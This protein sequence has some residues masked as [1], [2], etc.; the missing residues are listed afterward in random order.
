[1]NR[2]QFLKT[3]SLALTLLSSHAY[4]LKLE[5]PQ[6]GAYLGAYADFGLGAMTMN[7]S[8]SRS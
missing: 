5:P 2:S 1:M 7:I 8:Q 3:L 6:K 4:A